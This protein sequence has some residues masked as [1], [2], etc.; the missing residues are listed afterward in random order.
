MD[1]ASEASNLRCMARAFRE[2]RGNI[3]KLNPPHF[4]SERNLWVMMVKE[5]DQWIGL[6][7]RNEEK[8]KAYHR[9]LET[10]Q[11]AQNLNLTVQATT[12]TQ[13]RVK[14]A[15]YAFGILGQTPA[16]EIVQAVQFFND[17]KAKQQTP[18]ISEAA[19]LFYDRQSKRELSE[20][21]LRDY[22]RLVTNL[23]LTFG[24]KRVAEL[25][26]SDVTQFIEAVPY[27]AGKRARFIY[28]RAFLQFCSGKGNHHANGS[29]WLIGNPL[30]WQAPRTEMKEISVLK[31]DEIVRL[32]RSASDH[33]VLPYF[34]FRL[35]SMVRTEEMIRFVAIHPTVN[36]HPLINLE[37]QRISIT[38][39]IFKKR[40]HNQHRGRFYNQL[41]PTFLKWLEYFAKQECSLDCSPEMAFE[42][43]QMAG[44]PVAERN[45]LRHTAI[46][47]H[48]LL[49]RDPVKTAYVAGNSFGIIQNHYLN[50]NVPNEDV[51][52][53]YDL[54][55]NRARELGIL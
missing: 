44:R 53:L 32:L 39:Q 6:C 38:N 47:Y 50:M 40:S 23:K 2:I 13:E 28:L 8:I 3:T 51:A 11:T 20:F 42:V 36:G 7:S 10:Q 14:M 31:F 45:V 25:T 37:A 41:H 21:T 49:T 26:A 30:Q 46:T 43:K 33:R 22:R 18:T 15:E 29:S 1:C 17:H 9:Q 27:P 35:F 48:C 52:K 54:T 55:P 34:I 4:A 16:Q 5:N 12:L 19:D 24:T